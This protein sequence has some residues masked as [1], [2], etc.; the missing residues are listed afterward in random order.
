M[1]IH[2]TQQ[3][4]IQFTTLPHQQVEERGDHPPDR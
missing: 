2:H 3:N 4:K 1:H